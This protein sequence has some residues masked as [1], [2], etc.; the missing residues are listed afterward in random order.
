MIESIG[1]SG[2]F[3]PPPPPSNNTNASLS[4]EQSSLIEETLSNYDAS[5][6]SEADASAIVEAFSDAGITPSAQFADA[7]AESGFDAREIGSLANVGE[8]QQGGQR[9][10]PPPPNSDSSGGI[11]LSSVMEYLDSLSDSDTTSGANSTSMAAKLAEQFGLS[12]GQSL[13]NVTA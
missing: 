9:P 12:E 8:S 2:A 13:I 1:S 6:L 4:S 7:L 10:P 5:N 3:R 11:D